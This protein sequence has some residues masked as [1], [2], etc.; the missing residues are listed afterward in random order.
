MIFQHYFCC[1]PKEKC[2]EKDFI[3]AIR[4]PVCFCSLYIVKSYGA[5]LVENTHGHSDVN[6]ER[7]TIEKDIFGNTIIRD[8][9]GNRTTIKKDI[10]G[11]TVIENN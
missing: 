10:F 2:Y 11:N 8:N 9:K 7:K 4:S 3:Y 5:N 1:K 6:Q